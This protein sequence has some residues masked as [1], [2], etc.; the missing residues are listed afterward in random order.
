V[1]IDQACNFNRFTVEPV[2]RYP[3]GEIMSANP[4]KKLFNVHEYHQMAEAGILSRNDRVELIRGEI[5]DLSPF[6]PPHCAL[7][8]RTTRVMGRVVGDRA[9]FQIQGS[10]RLDLWGEP[11]P[12]FALLMPVDDFYISRHP[13]PQDVFLVMEVSDSSL[14]YDSEIK[15]RLYADTGVPEHWI[16]DIKNICLFANSDINE[17][18]YSTVRQYHRGDSE[19]AAFQHEAVL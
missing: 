1:K 9:I 11:Q 16:L 2:L 19:P 15:A 8:D 7:V 12:D 4:T 5:L 13:G 6:N 14:Q 18:T 3:C 10:V 17:N